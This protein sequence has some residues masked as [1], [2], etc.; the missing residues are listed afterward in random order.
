[1]RDSPRFCGVA[2]QKGDVMHSPWFGRLFFAVVAAIAVTG[3][4]SG[5][6]CTRWGKPGAVPPT[7]TPLSSI[8]VDAHTGSDSSGNGSAAKPYKTLTKAVEVL[9]SSKSLSTSGV[10]INL[11]G[12]DYNAANGEIFPIVVPTNVTIS[13]SNYGAGPKGGSFV[14]GLGQDTIFESLVHAPLR[15]AYATLEIVPPANVNLNG[16][17]V[18]ASRISLPSSRAAYFS[19]DLI[20]TLNVSLSSFGAGI[21][22][23]LRNV[24]GVLVAGG[25]FNCTSCQIHGNDVGIAALSIATASPSLVQ[26]SV[27]LSHS[28]GDSTIAAKLV[29]IVT[30]GSVNVTASG[31]TFERSAYAFSDAFP[32]VVS[33][34]VRGA[35]DFGGGAASSS[36]GNDFI[37]ARVTEIE[38][39]R[40]FETVSALD[41]T[42]N[43][44][45]QGAN[46][47]GQYLKQRTFGSGARG[48]NVT[49]L[50]D[51]T[52]S[53]VTVGPA[54]VPTPT[55]STTPSGSP[56]PTA[57][58]T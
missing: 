51:A 39:T 13:G 57:T 36:G 34:P 55:P 11:A 50:H 29:D 19:L 58:P 52:G 27:S 6:G 24:S 8:Y 33:V 20:G 56:G 9:A 45:Q 43:P 3:L 30:D 5:V 42:W 15:T 41:D 14:D 7:I 23:P 12:G 18:G 22:S 38:L 47:N 28:S 17:Y 25:T 49:I 31:E 35:V 4:V 10:T 37:G 48:K 53:T 1:V 46:R 26:P 16:V 44:A 54:P 32:Q 40:R 2:R 21:V